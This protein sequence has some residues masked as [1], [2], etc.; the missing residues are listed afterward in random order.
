MVRVPN[1]RGTTVNMPQDQHLADEV[2]DIGKWTIYVYYGFGHNIVDCYY[3]DTF[4]DSIRVAPVFEAKDEFRHRIS[5]LE[6]N[7]SVELEKI[8]KAS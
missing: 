5:W 8:R 2:E 6:E 1:Q 4:V 7:Y 3:L